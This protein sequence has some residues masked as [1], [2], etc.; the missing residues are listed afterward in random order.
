MYMYMYM[1]MLIPVLI[2]R[3]SAFYMH[4]R[5]GAVSRVAGGHGS[6]LCTKLH[7]VYLV[8]TYIFTCKSDN[9]PGHVE[10]V[11]S[12]AEHPGQ[13]VERGIGIAPPH[14]LMQC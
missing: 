10:W 11:F 1:Y 2:L 14:G 3:I 12:S 4:S 6:V 13:P 7:V 9:S 5:P 8:L